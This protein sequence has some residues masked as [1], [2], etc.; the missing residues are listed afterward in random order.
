MNGYSH[1]K[2]KMIFLIQFYMKN[3][4]FLKKAHNTYMENGIYLH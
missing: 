2:R 4:Q 3:F 1:F